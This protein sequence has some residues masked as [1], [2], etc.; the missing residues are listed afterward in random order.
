MPPTQARTV[1]M[2]SLRL[3]S[4]HHPGGGGGG[5]H[6]LTLLRMRRLILVNWVRQL[7]TSATYIYTSRTT[8]LG[9]ANQYGNYLFAYTSLSTP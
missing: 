9:T 1:V 8:T 6:L 5:V 2:V 7:R 4:I 3:L